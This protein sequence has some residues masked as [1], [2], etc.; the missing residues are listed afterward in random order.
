MNKKKHMLAILGAIAAICSTTN[1]A[2]DTPMYAITNETRMVK[3]LS[4][5]VELYCWQNEKNEWNFALLIG[6]NLIKT[7]ETI[8]SPANTISSLEELKKKLSVL[9]E[10]E[11][12]SWSTKYPK[13]P[14]DIQKS[15]G[16]F[17]N[18]LKIILN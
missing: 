2:P 4:K 5:G 6:T 3:R 15:I 1:A 7:D 13:P 8:R 12:V 14:E 18:Q 16:D 17:C 9:A 10:G 11:Y